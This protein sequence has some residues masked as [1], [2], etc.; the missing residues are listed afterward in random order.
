MSTSPLLG[1]LLVH[2]GVNFPNVFTSPFWASY[3]YLLPCMVVAGYTLFASSLTIFGLKEVRR[4]AFQPSPYSRYT[5]QTNPRI[6]RPAGYQAVSDV[7]RPAEPQTVP[8]GARELLRVYPMLRYI[9]ASSGAI[10]FTAAAFNVFFGLLAYS[11]LADGGLQLS[12][13]T[14]FL[15]PS[16]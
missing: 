15:R 1:G 12:V 5:L 9:S 2:P 8:P 13:R 10:G 4:V 6:T 16:Y 14:Y 11:N 7:E 3:P